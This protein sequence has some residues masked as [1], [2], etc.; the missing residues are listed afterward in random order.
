MRN[1]EVKQEAFGMQLEGLP[2]TF[3]RIPSTILHSGQKYQRAV[4][5]KWVQDIVENFN[6]LAMPPIVVSWRDGKFWIVDGQHRTSAMKRRNGDKDVIMPCYVVTGLTYEQEARLYRKLNFGVHRLGIADLVRSDV[7]SDENIDVTTI[8]QIL[9]QNGIEWVFSK[10]GV[11]TPNQVSAS[12]SLLQAY[13][14][15]SLDDFTRMIRLIKKTWKGAPH[16]LGS[17]ILLG[18]A[19]FFEIY[20]DEIDDKYFVEKFGKLSPEEIIAEGRADVNVRDTKLKYAKAIW[21]RYNLKKVKNR[22]AYQFDN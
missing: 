14:M 5:D 9:T 1:N 11:S 3:K 21:H 12:S 13:H 7:E 22:L 2:Y 8:K 20:A 16:S 19:L 17:Y 6:R 18:M 15:L 4:S 10:G